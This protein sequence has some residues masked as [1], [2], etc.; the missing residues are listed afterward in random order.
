MNHRT[1]L[2]CVSMSLPASL[3]AFGL[4]ACGSSGGGSGG[5]GTGGGGGGGGNVT[6]AGTKVIANEANDYSFSSTLTFPS[7]KVQPKAN[8]LFDWS[9]VKA[10]FIRHTIDPKKDLTMILI[11]EW[12]LNLSDL[13]TKI[14]ADTV[15]SR[16]LTIVPP[17]Q[18]NPEGKM[19]SAKL[20]DFKFN[21]SPIGGELVSVE[22]VMLFFDD[23]EYDPKTHTLTMMAATGETLGQGTKMIQSFILDPTSTN[24]T[25]TMTKDST[26]LDFQADLTRLTPTGIPSKQAN[27]TFDWSQMTTN[28]L[29][30]DFSGDNA[31]RITSAFIGHYSESASE[32]SGD[33]FLDLELIATQLF[34]KSIDTGTSVDLS[35]FTDSSN[36][37]FPG[38]DSSGTWLLGL[39]CGDCRNPA[40]WYL[41]VL[42]P[43]S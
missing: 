40:P 32:L 13:Q 30:A 41:T 25:V 18:I 43:C 31:N 6:C 29:G 37:H 26:H 12:E 42:K 34:R 9:E 16:D 7:I 8:L 10:D 39:Q 35:S 28:A 24:T 5:G 14:N 38:V 36:N 20:L 21:G 19:T 22:Q 2:H 15:E 4:F 27:V 33:K 3:L 17:L 23:K 1:F 11:F